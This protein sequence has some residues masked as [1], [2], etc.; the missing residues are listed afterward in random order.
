MPS[1][2]RQPQII[3]P[4]PIAPDESDLLEQL[5]KQAKLQ[6]IANRE[7]AKLSLED[8]EAGNIQFLINK[9]SA[10]RIMEDS[11]MQ[12]IE[13]KIKKARLDAMMKEGFTR[14]EAIKI[15]AKE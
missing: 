14:E 7:M 4:N 11:E 8:S 5:K 3:T 10:K 6:H 1:Q 12:K 13:A 9:A 2:F 15:I